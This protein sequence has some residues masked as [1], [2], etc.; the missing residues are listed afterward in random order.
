MMKHRCVV[1][2]RSRKRMDKDLYSFSSL[3]LL[4]IITE[5]SRM[6]GSMRKGRGG[7]MMP[8]SRHSHRQRVFA[9]N[10]TEE[11]GETFQSLHQAI[12]LD[13]LVRVTTDNA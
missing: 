9:G 5:E 1:I 3:N 7:L 11:P 2:Q 6:G 12:F 4:E 10:Q 8:L 13:A